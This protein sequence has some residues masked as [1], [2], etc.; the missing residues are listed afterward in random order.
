M[1]NGYTAAI[2]EGK[3]V[4]LRDYLMGIGRGMGFAILQRDADRDDPVKLTEPSTG[5]AERSLA[6][7]RT[8]RR[9]LEQMTP[10]DAQ[11][12]AYADF[13]DA[14]AR[15]EADLE[16][17]LAMR[18][19]YEDMIAQVEAWRPDPLVEGAKEMALRYLR[20]S[21]DFDC[22]KPGEEMR[23][24]PKPELLGG[25]AWLEREIAEA[26][27]SIAH[28]EKSIAEELERTA[29]RNRYIEAFLSS[30]PPAEREA[31]TP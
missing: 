22:G 9:V 10:E 18:A 15:W 11:A 24:R 29:E 16:K 5:H 12:A 14:T 7:A 13:K 6:D 28:Y 21:A 3:P 2:Y 27:R 31:N 20:E 17:S 25:R 23:Y 8:R 30:L 26:Q 1:P 19:R 4:T